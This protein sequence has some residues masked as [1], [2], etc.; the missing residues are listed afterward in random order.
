VILL[1]DVDGLFDADPRLHLHAR[2]IERVE[3]I[4]ETIMAF[5]GTGSGSG[6]G[7]GGMRSKL[8]AARIATTA[9]ISLA[10][11]NGR[12]DRPLDAERCTFF[13]GQS[14][15]SPRKAW[16]AGRL[17]VKGTIVVDSGA[18]QALAQGASLLA[19]GACGVEGRFARGDVIDI[20][21]EGVPIAR[22]LSEYDADDAAKL[23]GTKSAAQADILGHAPRSALV[24]RDHLVLL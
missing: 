3:S 10:I 14:G 16:L 1:S 12:R 15:A 18:A 9:G 13:V 2:L 5:A 6:M 17:T 22:G 7:S 20:A 23:A 11:A 24:H 19:A 4:D 8:Q 21:H